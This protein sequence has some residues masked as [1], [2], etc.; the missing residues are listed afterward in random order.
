MDNDNAYLFIILK[1][2]LTKMAD[3]DVVS[4]RA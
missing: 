4:G 2:K 3:N 1:K